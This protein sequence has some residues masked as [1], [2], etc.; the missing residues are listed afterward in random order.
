MMNKPTLTEEQIKAG[1]HIYQE[2][3][4]QTGPPVINDTGKVHRPT[5]QG[6]EH[7]KKCPCNQDVRLK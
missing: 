5:K 4:Y 6:F 3:T 2:F 7:W 1:F